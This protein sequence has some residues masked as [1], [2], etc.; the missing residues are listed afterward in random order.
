MAPRRHG[1]P[2]ARHLVPVVLL[3]ALVPGALAAGCRNGDGG[4]AGPDPVEGST[5][6]DA[7]AA[8]GSPTTDLHLT[9][10]PSS[11]S[12]GA[13]AEPAAAN[14]ACAPADLAVRVEEG[15]SAAG[16][17]YR[18]I[19]FV[20]TGTRACTVSGFPAVTFAGADGGHLPVGVRRDPVAAGSVTLASGSAAAAVLDLRNPDL[21]D[22]G[23]PVEATAVRI[24]PPGSAEAVTVP[25][26]ASVCGG[27]AGQVSVGPM[28]ADADSQP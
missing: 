25:L 7:G 17:R 24:T 3:L 28:V 10:P 5:P 23:P 20:N 12:A 26:A 15:G 8:S 6:S 27:D 22:C 18:R 1:S 13:P 16:H 4:A 14:G 19:V 2:A 9:D 21:S 11:P